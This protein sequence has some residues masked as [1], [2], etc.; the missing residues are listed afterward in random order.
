M[1]AIAQTKP[2]TTPSDEKVVEEKV[3]TES[4]DE[5]KDVGDIDPEL[6]SKPSTAKPVTKPSPSAKPS[7]T[8]PTTTP[9]TTKPTTTPI[10]NAK[11]AVPPKLP[12]INDG[13]TPTTENDPEGVNPV[14]LSEK[15]D[16]DAEFEL[17]KGELP[18][19]DSSA[20]CITLLTQ[21]A[22]VNSPAIKSLDQQIQQSEANVRSIAQAGSGNI[23][24]LIQP[25][26]PFFSVAPVPL[27]LG[28]AIGTVITNFAGNVRQDQTIAQNNATL[29]IRIAELE[30]G[31]IDARGRIEDAL[32]AAVIAFDAAKIQTDIATA[33]ANRESGRF[34]LIEIGYRLGEGDTN[35]F[36]ALQ[37]GL[38]RTRLDVTR[39]KSAMRSQAAKIKRIV[40]GDES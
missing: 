17:L 35:S 23:F 11:K 29:Q 5:G 10:P 8:K 12:Q 25:F 39:Q 18:C 14:E 34:K 30:R 4:F 28:T 7:T 1:E 20:P 38:D 13:V 3:Q 36:I 22:F 37:N 32:V 16:K 24:S 15:A 21:R 40:L 9:N 19:L 33:I 26:T 6:K 27:A 31:K 2:P